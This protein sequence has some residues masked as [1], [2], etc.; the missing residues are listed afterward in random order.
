MYRSEKNHQLLHLSH[1]YV[2]MSVYQSFLHLPISWVSFYLSV[3]L[4][5]VPIMAVC[6]NA[7]MHTTVCLPANQHILHKHYF[8][9]LGIAST[10]KFM[11]AQQYIPGHT[12]GGSIILWL[13]RTPRRKCVQ[14]MNTRYFQY[15]HWYR[16]VHDVTELVADDTMLLIRDYRLAELSKVIHQHW[17]ITPP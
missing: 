5:V 6:Q 7:C 4:S 14:V 8:A 3:T 17:T 11:Y 1:L 16:N 15:K 10:Y 12:N 9:L 13:I 2:C